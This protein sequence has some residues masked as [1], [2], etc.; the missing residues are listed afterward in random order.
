MNGKIEQW[1]YIS[2]SGNP[3]SQIAD[4]KLYINYN[5]V[6]SYNINFTPQ[7]W[8]DGSNIRVG[9]IGCTRISNN[10]FKTHVYGGS[11]S[12]TVIGSHWKTVGY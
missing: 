4:V 5:T 9:A 8:S 3:R 11:S 12:D 7:M 2:V 1:G 6:D 10:Q